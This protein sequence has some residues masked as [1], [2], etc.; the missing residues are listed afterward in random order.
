[1]SKPFRDMASRKDGSSSVAHSPFK[2]RRLSLTKS[3]SPVSLCSLI[4]AKLSTDSLGARHT[5][6]LRVSR[7][8][9][10][11]GNGTVSVWS[12]TNTC[13][14]TG[15]Y[16]GVAPA[17]KMLPHSGYRMVHGLWQDLNLVHAPLQEAAAR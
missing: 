10:V 12:T 16:S 1:M 4:C 15:A 17:I 7:P 11:S 9:L 3:S 14:R 5:P 13:H 2:L 6:G 8:V